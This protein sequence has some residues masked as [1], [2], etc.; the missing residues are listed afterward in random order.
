[1]SVYENIQNR[2]VPLGSIGIFTVVSGVE[3][4][5]RRLRDW[6][7]R[8]RTIAALRRL[9]DDQLDDI[10]LCRGDVTDLARGH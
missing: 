7:E 2:P 3:T 1:M 10:G 9:N 8:R 6:N 4:L 5:L